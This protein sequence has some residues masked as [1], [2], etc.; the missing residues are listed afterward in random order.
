MSPVMLLACQAR[1]PAL[2]SGE[3]R[4]ELVLPSSLDSSAPTPVVFA[5]HGASPGW[6]DAVD[7][8]LRFTAQ[9]EQAEREGYILV[10]P[11]AR[12]REDRWR[13]W[14]YTPEEAAPDIELVEEI[15]VELEERYDIDEQAVY[16]TGFSSG[17]YFSYLL[18]TERP[19]LLAGVGVVAA[20]QLSEPV[21][22]VPVVAFNGR[23]DRRVRHAEGQNAVAEVASAYGVLKEASIVLEGE[24]VWCRRWRHE[25]IIQFCSV[26]GGHTWPG[27]VAGKRVLGAFGEG[28]TT[29]EIDA[30]ERM[31]ALLH[32]RRGG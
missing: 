29:L 10:A 9:R 6:V 15:L 1:G 13:T 8:H 19:G 16:S 17:G 23:S 21:G 18:A 25:E 12:Q 24:E 26:E 7:M 5:F 22:A 11:E 2:E 32:E 4:V 30:T 31:W 28:H 3:R 27:S 14:R 20:G